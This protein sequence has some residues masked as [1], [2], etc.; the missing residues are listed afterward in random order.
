MTQNTKMS[1]GRFSTYG[2]CLLASLA[3][4]ACADGGRPRQLDQP[5]VLH[6]NG[7][8]GGEG[9]SALG[10]GGNGSLGGSSGTGD[11]ELDAGT[12]GYQ[13]GTDWDGNTNP[14][15]DHAHGIDAAAGID[16]RGN[17]SPEAGA[18]GG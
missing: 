4:T 16:A 9:G 14:T 2:L 11:D 17:G 3:F 1:L 5:G 15:A 10:P 8:S 13:I 6:D 18:D 7:G 12:G